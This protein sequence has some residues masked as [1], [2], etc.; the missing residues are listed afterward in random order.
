MHG[1]GLLRSGGWR[2]SEA[3]G[4]EHEPAA[5]AGEEHEEAERPWWKDRGIMVPIF[6]GVAF[7]GV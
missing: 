5:T 1:G 7:L 4:C 2:V 3:C 6:S